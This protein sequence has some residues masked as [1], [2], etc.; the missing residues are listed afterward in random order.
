MKYTVTINLEP[1][2]LDFN[3]D[4]YEDDFIKS[5]EAADPDEERS[6]DADKLDPRNESAVQ[7]FITE[8]INDNGLRELVEDDPSV[9][10]IK[11]KKV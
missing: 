7:E 4:D 2:V 6:D 11:L 1:I 3:T 9:S 8:F 5:A 10:S